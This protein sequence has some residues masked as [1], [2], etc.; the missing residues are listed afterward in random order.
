MVDARTFQ[1][2]S[3][4][5]R[6]KILSLLGGGS[7]NVSAMVE[8]LDCTQ[9]AVSRHLK[10]LKQAGLIVDTRRGKWIEYSSNPSTVAEAA[11]YL[12]AL[13]DARRGVARDPGEAGA[14]VSE[15][16]EHISETAGR[17]RGSTLRPS[18]S[19]GR[20]RRSPGRA[21]K[22]AEGARKPAVP[23]RKAA[24]GSRKSPGGSGDSEER[25][26]KAAVGL[27]ESLA[28]SG[29]SGE[30]ARKPAEPRYVI[31]ARRD[32]IDDLML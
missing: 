19:T 10:V 13:H 7:M 32:F 2:L 21:R 15:S 23:P 6:L 31:E 5:T 18:G 11:E 27:R 8:K 29:G 24:V 3:D 20:P 22:R 30:P 28:G 4:P 1:A 16:A 25:P 14:H 17:A 26:R 9:P 12:K